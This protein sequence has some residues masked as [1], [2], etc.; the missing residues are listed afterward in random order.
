MTDSMEAIAVDSRKGRHFERHF[1]ARIN[2][3]YQQLMRKIRMI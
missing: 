1:G 3:T 2:R